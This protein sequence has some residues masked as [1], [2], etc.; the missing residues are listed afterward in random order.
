MTKWILTCP[1]CGTE[2]EVLK[3]MVIIKCGIVSCRCDCTNCKQGLNGQQEYWQWLG[4]TEAPPDE[5]DLEI[6]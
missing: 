6:T 1:N 3:N 5:L 2:N 4:L